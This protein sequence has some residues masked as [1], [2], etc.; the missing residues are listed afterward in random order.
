MTRIAF[1]GSGYVGLI[2]A[3]CFADR[4]FDVI[5]ADFDKSRIDSIR[6]GEPPFYEAGLNQLLKKVS[7]S[8]KLR[9][10]LKTDEAVLGSEITFITVGT[11]SSREGQIDLTY[12]EN[13]AKEIGAALLGKAE[14]HMVVVKSTVVPEQQWG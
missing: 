6:S 8:G 5:V 7:L 2:T 14:Y 12:V 10:T 4:G 3:A 13:C 1:I 11:P 9:S